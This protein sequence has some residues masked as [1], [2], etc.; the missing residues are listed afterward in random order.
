MTPDEK[1]KAARER[2][3]RRIKRMRAITAHT[4]ESCDA[5]GVVL[6]VSFADQDETSV[7]MSTWGNAVL[8]REMVRAARRRMRKDV[9]T[10]D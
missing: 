9:D 3:Q 7:R 10:N 5:D 8:C 4:V 6:I 1:R 2:L